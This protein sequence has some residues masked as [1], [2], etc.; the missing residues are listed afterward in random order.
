MRVGIRASLG[1]VNLYTQELFKLR[2]VTAIDDAALSRADVV[3]L[4][5]VACPHLRRQL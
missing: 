4:G 5:E 1:L 2:M 3:S